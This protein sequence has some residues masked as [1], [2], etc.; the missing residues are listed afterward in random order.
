MYNCTLSIQQRTCIINVLTHIEYS[1]MA[2]YT[3]YSNVELE[4]CIVRVRRS[5]VGILYA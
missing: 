5:C 1:S 3:S 2:I 4:G